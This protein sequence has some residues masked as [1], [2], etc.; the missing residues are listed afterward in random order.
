MK[1]E[2]KIGVVIE[3]EIEDDYDFD[4]IGE[5]ICA[6][7]YEMLYNGEDYVEVYYRGCEKYEDTGLFS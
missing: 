2:L 3:S 4:D 5:L 6:D 1:V 7:L